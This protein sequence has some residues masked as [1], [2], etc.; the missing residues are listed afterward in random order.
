MPFLSLQRNKLLNYWKFLETLGQKFQLRDLS[1]KQS[2][3]V[4]LTYFGLTYNYENLNKPVVL[5]SHTWIISHC[6]LQLSAI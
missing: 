4:V 6:I 5:Y 1:G 2:G 3:T